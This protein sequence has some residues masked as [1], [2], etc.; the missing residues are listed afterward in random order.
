MLKKTYLTL[1]LLPLLHSSFGQ[2]LRIFNTLNN[3][4]VTNASITIQS[5]FNG[6]FEGFESLDLGIKVTN[7]SGNN[8]EVG[9]KKIEEDALQPD[10]QHTICFGGNCYPAST[11]VSPSHV[12]LAPGISDSGFVAHYLFDNTVHVRGVNHISYVF[13]N[14]QQPSDSVVVHVTYNTVM[15]AGIPGITAVNTPVA[16]PVPATDHI[17]FLNVQQAPKASM[18]LLVTDMKGTTIALPA[19]AQQ[20]TFSTE[21]L[22]TG[23]YYYHLLSD[24]GTIAMGRIMIAH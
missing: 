9:A 7:V 3:A 13:Y 21:Q 20:A 12:Y 14:V 10:V 19:T 8:V 11:Y 16:Y 17:S 2:S 22:P 4:D 23:I 6:G 1:L 24:A 15:A 5:P 18:Q